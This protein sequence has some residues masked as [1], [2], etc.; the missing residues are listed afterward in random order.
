MSARANYATL[1]CHDQTYRLRI[2]PIRTNYRMWDDVWPTET[3]S[4]FDCRRVKVKRDLTYLPTKVLP[5]PK[6]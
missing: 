6:V 5:F 2:L 3:Y 4:W 1:K